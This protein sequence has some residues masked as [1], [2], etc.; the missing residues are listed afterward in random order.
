[1]ERI[2]SCN[3]LFQCSV[4][5]KQFSKRSTASRHYESSHNNR[6]SF[7]CPLPGCNYRASRKDTLQKHLLSHSKL[8]TNQI[9]E[10]LGLI[11]VKSNSGD[12]TH[13]T[14]KAN[15]EVSAVSTSTEAPRCSSKCETQATINQMEINRQGPV[16]KT[17]TQLLI[18]RFLL[19]LCY[20]IRINPMIPSKIISKQP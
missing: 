12:S 16:V 1:M 6:L 3:K 14:T 18:A 5:G 8:T 20:A 4:C 15:S 13:D 10:K 11:N 7:H 19:L 9:I 17:Y 2:Y